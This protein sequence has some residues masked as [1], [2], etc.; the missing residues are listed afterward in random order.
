[1]YT[2]TTYSRGRALS[3]HNF[4]KP[5]TLSP[6]MISYGRRT[7]EIVQECTGALFE[8]GTRQPFYD[9]ACLNTADQCYRRKFYNI[10]YMC[11][12]EALQI[13]DCLDMKIQREGTTELRMFFLMQ[14][15]HSVG[16]DYRF[17][18]K[19]AFI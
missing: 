7:K 17:F 2:Y 12:Q 8:P 3:K 11:L 13:E 5:C 10:G 1:M 19:Q 9:V 18:R 4:Y 16:E 14:L 15:K 6:T